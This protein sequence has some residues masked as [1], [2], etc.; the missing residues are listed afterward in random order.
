[1][2]PLGGVCDN[3][4]MDEYN[5]KKSTGSGDDGSVLTVKL[6]ICRLIKCHRLGEGRDAVEVIGKPTAS[7]MKVYASLKINF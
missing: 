1:M 2:C 4:E 6:E 7:E 5:S 3:L